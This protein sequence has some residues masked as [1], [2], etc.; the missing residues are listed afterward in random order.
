MGKYYFSY[1]LFLFPALVTALF[2]KN[3]SAASITAQWFF[4]LVLLVG[5]TF[6]TYLAAYPYPRRTLSLILMYTGI[7]LII[8]YFFYKSVY[9]T[10]QYI[11]LRD[12]GGALSYVPLGVLIDVLGDLK[13]NIEVY[14]ILAVASCMLLGYLAALVKRR[15]KPYPYTP[16]IR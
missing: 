11:F 12:Y 14:V 13:Q 15:V 4:A 5:F 10:S 8:F 2:F 3:D 16:K 9:G 1:A 7:N 6:T